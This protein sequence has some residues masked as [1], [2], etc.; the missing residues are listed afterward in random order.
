[1]DS[2]EPDSPTVSGGD[3]GRTQ[4]D[5]PETSYVEVEVPLRSAT[6]LLCCRHSA[7]TVHLKYNIL[8]SSLLFCLVLCTLLRQG[9]TAARARRRRQAAQ[10]LLI[11]RSAGYARSLPACASSPLNPKTGSK[12]SVLL[13]GCQLRAPVPA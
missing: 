6:Q 5:V 4:Q 11:W 1:M 13:R 9:R 2:K 3:L 7:I 12:V 10:T 8:C